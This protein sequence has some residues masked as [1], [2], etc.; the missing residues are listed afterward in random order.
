MTT[1][2]KIDQEHRCLVSKCKGRLAEPLWTYGRYA[3]WRKGPN[4]MWGWYSTP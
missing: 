2:Q 3:Y 4:D 1:S